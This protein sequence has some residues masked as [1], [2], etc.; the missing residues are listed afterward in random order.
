[1]N[2]NI[3]LFFDASN[4]LN[5]PGRRY[6]DPGNLLRATNV[7]SPDRSDYTIEWERFGRRFGGGVRVTF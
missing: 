6:S 2:E 1:V 5:N 4:L 3:E 7:A